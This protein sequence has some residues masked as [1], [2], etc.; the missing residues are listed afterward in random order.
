M[1]LDIFQ[2]CIK[3]KRGAL[4]SAGYIFSAA[5]ETQLILK[6]IQVTLSA[7]P[8][9]YTIVVTATLLNKHMLTEMSKWKK[10][11][12]VCSHP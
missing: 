5:C 6:G 10:K 12:N 7:I 1:I 2:A 8:A 4:N 11:K 9:A 3:V